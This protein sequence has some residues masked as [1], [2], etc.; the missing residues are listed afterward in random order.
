MKIASAPDYLP[1]KGAD[2]NGVFDANTH[3]LVQHA[4]A[5]A[6]EEGGVVEALDQ[7]VFCLGKMVACLLARLPESDWLEIAGS[8]RIKAA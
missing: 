7:Q 4:L 5:L 3:W 2:A 8:H 6:A 1:L